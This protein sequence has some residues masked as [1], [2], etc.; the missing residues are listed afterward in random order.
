MSEQPRIPRPPHPYSGKLII[1]EGIDGSGKST[2]LLLL[3]K[4]LE[5]K[6]H[7]VFFTEWNSSELVKDTT[8]RGKKNKSL[9]PTTFS[10]L[11]ATDFASRL[12]HE[13]LP[14]LKAG[15]IVLADRY[16]YTAF[17]RD[18][19]R[20]VSPEWIRKLYSFAITPDMAFYFKVPIEVAVSRLLGGTRG[21]FKYYEAGMD[22]N[23]SP[24]VTES[25]RIFQSNILAQYE[26]IV[27]EFQLITIDATKDI[28][29]QQN[30]MRLL[31]GEALKD[32][33]PRRG[34]H[35]RRTV[36]WRRFEEPKS[37]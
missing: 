33:K 34:T 27:D 19:A 24:D 17:A 12:Y 31:V 16:M 4:W 13:I 21:Q 6:G 37:E 2:Q 9:T 11:H 25:F 22:M 10:L 30:N 20:G 36:F 7:R 23:L 3:H 28:E 18:V 8:K 32:Y 29:S 14:P 35:G 15:M 5:S 26:K 1:V